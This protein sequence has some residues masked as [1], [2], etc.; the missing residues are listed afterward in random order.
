MRPA[1]PALCTVAA[2]TLLA[3]LSPASGALAAP[4]TR[5]AATA[6]TSLSGPVSCA[7]AD[8]ETGSDDVRPV[9]PVSERSVLV[10]AS[11]HTVAAVSDSGQVLPR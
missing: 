1:R 8:V 2:A 9:R 5:S 7:V 6:P 10:R 4:I 11:R 3:G